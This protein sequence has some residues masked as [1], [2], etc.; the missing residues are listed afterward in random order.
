MIA[1]FFM[2]LVL[3]FVGIPLIPLAFS[4]ILLAFM[5]GFISVSALLGKFVLMKFSRHH[6]PSVLRETMLGLILWWIIGWLPFYAGMMI[7]VLVI[8]T[9]FGGVL[10]ALFYRRGLP[11]PSI[12]DGPPSAENV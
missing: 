5:F 2:L 12:S 7:K 9:G 10:L 8:T 3:S 4:V 11:S 1:P 6:K